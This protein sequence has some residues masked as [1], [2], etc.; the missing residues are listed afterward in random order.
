MEEKENLRQKIQAEINSYNTIGLK[1][2]NGEEYLEMLQYVTNK[3][4]DLVEEYA[5]HSP[6]SVNGEEPLGYLTRKELQLNI[7]RNIERKILEDCSVEEYDSQGNLEL[8]YWWEGMPNWVK[9]Q[10]FLNGNSCKAGSGSSTEQCRFLGVDP[11][12]KTFRDMTPSK[13]DNQ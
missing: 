7:M 3:I 2:S 6:D 11:D 10:T 13:G 1:P 9:V 4:M 8:K 5:R 12:G